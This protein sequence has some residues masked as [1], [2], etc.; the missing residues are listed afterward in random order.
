MSAA[1]RI[2]VIGAGSWGGHIAAALTQTRHAA[3]AGVADDDDARAEHVAKSNHARLFP[4]IDDALTSSDVDA[5]AIALPNDLH[6]PVALRAFESGK[7]VLLEKPM[8]L[9]VADATQVED[10]ALA[11]GRVVMVDHIQRFYDPLVF[12]AELVASGRLGTVQAASVTRRDFL[13]REKSWL[14]KRRRVGGMLY[15][16]A[17]HEYDFLCWICGPACEVRC[18]RASKVV[19]SDTLDY[20]DVILTQLRFE[21]GAVGQVWN[22]MTDPLMG[23]DGTVTATNGSA[24]FDLYDARVRFCVIGEEPVERRFEPADGWGPGAWIATGGLGLGEQRAL[25]AVLEDF[26]QAVAGAPPRGARARDGAHAVEIAQAGYLSIAERR[27]V[28][29]PLRD[30]NRA[31]ATYLEDAEESLA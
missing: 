20:P 12:I 15:Q 27:P 1:L 30:D 24:W 25:R 2:A 18:L 7:H 14:Q 3:L 13:R 4:A 23:Y 26:A 5:V 11:H 21:S 29:L 22:C 28:V 10:A 31:R 6:A 19:A 17:C 8:S 9:T 16:S